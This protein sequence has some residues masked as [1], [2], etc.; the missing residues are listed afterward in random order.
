[1]T[2]SRQA[3]ADSETLKNASADPDL[4]TMKETEQA[5]LQRNTSEIQ[6]MQ[7]LIANLYLKLEQS[8]QRT[9]FIVT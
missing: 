5:K 3:D 8:Q 6:K 9:Q 1:M 7:D 4:I 2:E